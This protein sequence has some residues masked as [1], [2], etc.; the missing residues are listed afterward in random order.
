MS[1][2]TAFDRRNFLF[3]TIAAGAG[4]ALAGPFGALGARVAEAAPARGRNGGYGQLYPVRDETTG[5][6]LLLLP[7]GFEYL[8][9][10][11]TNDPMSDGTP[12]PSAHDGMAA[13][14]DG[15]IVRLVRNHERG[16]GPTFARRRARTTRA[17][18]AAPRTSRST[19]G[20]ASGSTATRASAARSATAPAVRRRATRG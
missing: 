11:W 2:R 5:L 10:G 19:P 17:R 6:P 15:S 9:Y 3:G 12:T 7:R 8:S 18:P 20:A 4:A 13:F 1:T 14:R 16:A